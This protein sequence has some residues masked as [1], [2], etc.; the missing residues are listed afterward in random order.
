MSI[1]VA[2]KPQ[3]SDAEAYKKYCANNEIVCQGSG[4]PLGRKRVEVTGMR[5]KSKQGFVNGID[6]LVRLAPIC[7]QA[8]KRVGWLNNQG[9]YDWAN[10]PW[11]LKSF[12]RNIAAVS[13]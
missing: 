5:G 12:Q 3:I 13:K 9:V 10:K 1:G 7:S 8:T 4:T 2:N 6:Q 11:T